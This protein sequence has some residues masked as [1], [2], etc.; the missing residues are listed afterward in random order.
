MTVQR[1]VELVFW[2]TVLMSSVVLITCSLYDLWD[3]WR[4]RNR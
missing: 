4:G 2:L 1:I 3:I